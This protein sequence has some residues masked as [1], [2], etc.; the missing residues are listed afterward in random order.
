MAARPA[1]LAALTR[2]RQDLG[3]PLS[4]HGLSRPDVPQSPVDLAGPHHPGCPGRSLIM[5]LKIKG[6]IVPILTLYHSSEGVD[7]Q[8]MQ[9]LADFLIERGV[10][11]LFPGGT[12]GEGP[13]LTLAERME[14][15]DICVEAARGRVPVI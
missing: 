12:T 6:V 2:R 5:Q 14:L 7:H 8:G 4:D 11:A 13:L 10:H 3:C 9:A 1:L 15:A